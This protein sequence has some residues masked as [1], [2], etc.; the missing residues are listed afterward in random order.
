MRRRNSS[1]L[2]GVGADA[3]DLAD[4]IERRLLRRRHVAA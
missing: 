3:A 2:D 1:F 4:D